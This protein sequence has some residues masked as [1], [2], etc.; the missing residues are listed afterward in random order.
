M[1]LLAEE[2]S[3]EVVLENLIYETIVSYVETSSRCSKLYV[4]VW[5]VRPLAAGPDVRLLQWSVGDVAGLLHFV[6]REYG[7]YHGTVSSAIDSFDDVSRE[8][9][10]SSGRAYRLMWPSGISMDAE[11][12][13]IRLRQLN[14]R[15]EWSSPIDCCRV[16]DDAT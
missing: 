15:G 4:P 6:G 9:V 2:P 3:D 11:C 5:D 1:Q 14:R 8:V 12:R 10:T 13:S 16:S 7:H